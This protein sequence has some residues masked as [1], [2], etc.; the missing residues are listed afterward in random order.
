MIQSAIMR[1]N[2]YID[3]F[4]LYFGAVKGTPY[5]WL[6]VQRLCE[7]LLPPHD[8]QS[9]K[10]FTARISARASDPQA[11]TRQQ[12]YLRALATRP[13]VRLFY[14]HYTSHEVTL[15]LAN[16][17]PVRFARVIRTDEKGSDVNLAVHLVNDCHTL[18][19]DSVVVVT[20]DSDLAEALRIAKGLGK[21]V[22]ILN[23]HRHPSNKLAQ[24][25]TFQKSIRHGVLA[26]CQ[27]PNP[28]NDARG[29]IHKPA[30]W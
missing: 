18:M 30:G 9:V 21:N 19:L 8:I 20:N 26:A 1:T 25:C 23:P 12:A 3:G 14:G 7:Q 10:Y 13:K 6:D 29:P 17:T 15:P 22:G 27:L 24:H 11:P 5:K 2:V 16:T 28:V 4:N